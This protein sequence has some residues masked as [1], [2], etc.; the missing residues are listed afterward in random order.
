MYPQSRGGH[1]LVCGEYKKFPIKSSACPK[2]YLCSP[3]GKGALI[4]VLFLVLQAKEVK[5]ADPSGGGRTRGGHLKTAGGHRCTWGLR[6]GGVGNPNP[7]KKR[8][9]GNLHMQIRQNYGIYANFDL[10]YRIF[11][12]KMQN[13]LDLRPVFEGGSEILPFFGPI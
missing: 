9:V 3:T 6:L 2:F 13:F 11:R 12:P 8:R 5:G 10:K 4:L 7:K 1:V